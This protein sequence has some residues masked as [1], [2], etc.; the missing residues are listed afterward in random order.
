MTRRL[1][2][3]EYNEDEL[4]VIRQVYPMHGAK[5][6]AQ[7]LA[8]LPRLPGRPERTA[9]G[10]GSKANAMGLL[11]D[12]AVLKAQ[13]GE[14]LREGRKRIGMPKPV[15]VEDPQVVAERKRF[16]GASSVFGLGAVSTSEGEQP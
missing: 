9:D 14:I 3:D 12:R 4:E 5:A 15:V 8:R 6:C 1:R 13:R 10:V 7:A 11:V 16:L 2:P